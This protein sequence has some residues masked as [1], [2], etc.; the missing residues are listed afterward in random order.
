MMRI[1][2]YALACS[3]LLGI[4]CAQ[5]A[6]GDDIVDIIAPFEVSGTDPSTAGD[7]FLKMNVAETLVSADEAGKPL[8]GLATAWDLTDSGRTWR[9]KLRSDVVFHDGTPLTA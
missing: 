1:T 4:S 3:A 7:L 5:S 9:F 8:P 2:V 6:A